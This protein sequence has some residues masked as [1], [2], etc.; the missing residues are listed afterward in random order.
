MLSVRTDCRSPQ[1]CRNRTQKGQCRHHGGTEQR[2]NVAMKLVESYPLCC[3]RSFHRPALPNR[4][5]TGESERFHRI[6]KSIRKG[7]GNKN[8]GQFSTLRPARASA[9]ATTGPT[10]LLTFLFFCL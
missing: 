7:K 4:L 1:V 2:V 10:S 8:Y 9:A 6:V 5:S 3:S